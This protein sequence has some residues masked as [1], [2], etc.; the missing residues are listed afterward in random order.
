MQRRK[1]GIQA[2]FTMPSLTGA[3]HSRG[4]IKAATLD[5]LH[6]PFVL[7][8]TSLVKSSP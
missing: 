5:R 3:L 4:G 2:H 7:N 6:F 8:T 1:L